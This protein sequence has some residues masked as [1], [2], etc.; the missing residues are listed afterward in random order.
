MSIRKGLARTFGGMGQERKGVHS[1]AGGMTLDNP[2]GWMTGEDSSLSTDKAMK[3]STVSR[4]VELRSNTVANL[5]VYIM[6]ERSKERIT[7]H[8]LG[9]VLWD[10]ANEA[11]TRFDY[12]RLMQVN[13]D[14]KGNAYAWIYRAAATGYPLELIPLASDYVVPRLD[15][16]GRLWYFYIHPKTGQI[17]KIHPADMLHYKAFSY[18]GI[19]GVSILSRASQVIQT[20]CSA[21]QHEKS[22]YDNGGRPSG[23][24]TTD[25]DI[26]GDKEIT[27]SNGETIK[28][29][30]K[31]F[32]RQEW[33]RVH[34]GAENAFRVAVLDNGLKYQ[35]IAMSLSDAQFVES[36]ELRVADMCR[37]FGVPPHLV[38]AGTQSYA[39]NEQNSLEYVKYTLLA[40]VTQREQEDTYKLLLP[41]DRADSLRIKREMKVYL[42]GDT[43]AQ[44]A[45]YKA[46]REIGG[47][48]ANDIRASEDLG[49]VPGGDEYYASW[50]YGPLSRWSELS[51]LRAMGKIGEP[52]KEE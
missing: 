42:R 13:R 47:Y 14:L 17:T 24:L 10:R 40:D 36:S 27:L 34:S 29:P 38:Y 20:A 21:Q 41:S 35:A 44:A 31:E 11:M 7:S 45:W 18:D 32:L 49:S 30:Q 33:D 19:T 16:Q 50:N 46:L 51:V 5:P 3:V 39:S 15:E 22:M 1:P 43:A 52:V 26:G 37:Y 2:I 4:C 9:C 25:A 6:N 28:I 48:S 8:R 12:E 23:V